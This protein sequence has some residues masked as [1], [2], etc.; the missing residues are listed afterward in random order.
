MPKSLRPPIAG[1][2]T[3]ENVP[4]NDLR[5]YQNNPR[6]HPK[7]Q[8]DK[9]A[10]AIDEFGFLI[11]LLIDN[12]NKVLAGHARLEAADKLSLP[13]VPCIR[14]TH[15][16]EAQKRTFIILDNRLSEDAKWDFQLLAKEIEFLQDEGIDLTTT[17][18]EIPEIEMIFDA[19]TPNVG[20]PATDDLL[21]DLDP[22]NVITRRG[23]LWIL[24]NHRIFCGDA[25]RRESFDI[26]LAGEV[27]QLVFI[28]PPYNVKI[29]S[30]VSGKGRVKHREFVHASGE[31]TPAQFTK[32]LEES[33][34]LL[35]E[36]S[37]DGAIH[38][39][40]SDWRHLD[41]MLAAGRRTYRELK[42]LVVWN[43]TNA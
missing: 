41:E 15:L 24:G 16:T 20:S 27:A 11:P 37:I 35:A 43:K 19:V 39:I 31:K 17:G 25:R 30:H 4:I 29:R 23:D 34:S 42:N 10:R 21:P 7:S 12:K 36:H 2:L 3:I 33:L 26:L 13:R 22:G 32:F 28:D 6:L 14:A 18:F 40:C 9:L 8:I 1:A 38:F 5:R